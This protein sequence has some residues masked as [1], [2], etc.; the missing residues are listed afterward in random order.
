[1]LLS[2][3]IV[4]EPVPFNFFSAAKK[5]Y[6]K[7]RRYMNIVTFFFSKK[8]KNAAAAINFLK[9]NFTV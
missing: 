9:I 2:G 8:T 5:S 4:T 6:K 1:M 3:I 7:C